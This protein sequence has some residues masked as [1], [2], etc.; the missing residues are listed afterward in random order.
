MIRLHLLLA[1]ALLFYATLAVALP[2]PFL[3]SKYANASDTTIHIKA[4]SGLQFDLV[5]F[6][7]RPGTKV[8]LIVENTDDM[9]HNFV[10]TQP[11]Q[12]TPVVNEALA[13]GEKGPA[14]HYI[15]KSP[16]VLW[17]IPTINPDQRRTLTFTAPAKEDVYPY[18]C[19]YPGHGFIMFGAMYVTTKPLPALKNDPHIPA[20]RMEEAA[21]THTPHAEQVSPH[22]FPVTLPMVYR[23]FIPDCG[24]AAIVVMLPNEQSYCFDAGKC[25]LR[26]AW[27]GYVDNSDHWKGNGKNI[28]KVVGDVYFKDQSGFPLRIGQADKVPHTQFRGYQLLERY[29]QF[30]YSIEEATVKELVKSLPDGNGLTREFQI[31]GATQPIYYI[32]KATDGVAYRASAGQFV[33]GILTL[34]PAQAQHFTITLTAKKGVNP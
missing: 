24:P 34:T 33:N 31:S 4:V 11:G 7:V 10:I 27:Q 22:P 21:A 6:A 23:T 20:Q 16:K 29:P 32:T 8:T 2:S 25:Y 30:T 1:V 15:P 19:T 14:L 5:R 12:R 26:F 18:V 28:A 3:P 17:S 13:L 9:E